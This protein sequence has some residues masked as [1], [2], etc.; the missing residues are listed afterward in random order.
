VTYQGNCVAPGPWTMDL[1][2]GVNNQNV[3]V[4]GV[5]KAP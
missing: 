2:I 4:T 5:V 3:I 1:K